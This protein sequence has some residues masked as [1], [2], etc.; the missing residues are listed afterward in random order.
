M[1]ISFVGSGANLIY[2]AGVA[3]F[4]QEKYDISKVK[5]IGTSGGAII[6]TLLK[7]NYDF[8]NFCKES[9][10][11]I[12]SAMNSRLKIAN[13]CY[14]GMETLTTHLIKNYDSDS[15]KELNNSLF[16][17]VTTM[18]L[19]NFLISEFENLGDIVNAVTVSCYVPIIFYNKCP[20]YKFRNKYYLG[21]DGGISNNSPVVDD[22][23]VIICP[24]NFRYKNPS[25][26]GYLSVFS[27]IKL[28]DLYD[29]Q[30]IFE[31]G[32]NDC[33]LKEQLLNSLL[34]P[35]KS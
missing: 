2:Q 5:I 16:I 27:M 17:G 6:A 19:K 23:T 8:N 13:L 35:R 29:I 22:D 32:Y 12:C 21:M 4:I 31:R 26:N 24:H 34:L 3:K 1:S 15:V 28:Y 11:V 20:I 33:K 14:F 25:I 18:T 9:Q 30:N 7:T 10:H